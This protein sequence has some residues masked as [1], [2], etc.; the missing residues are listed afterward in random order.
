MVTTSIAGKVLC[1]RDANHL[2][3]RQIPATDRLIGRN[4]AAFFG[5]GSSISPTDRRCIVH[6]QAARMSAYR[7]RHTPVL[8][9]M[10]CSV[11]PSSPPQLLNS[12]CNWN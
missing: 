1:Q 6:Q 10:R 12:S 8:E 11:S 4:Y 9:E 7:R 5:I 3:S 2:S